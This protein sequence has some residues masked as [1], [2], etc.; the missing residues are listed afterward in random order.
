MSETLTLRQLID[1]T[2]ETLYRTAE[3]PR[4]V[5]LGTAVSSSTIARQIVLTE[6][7]PY[8][9]T[10]DTLEFGS[11]LM[12]VTTKTEQVNPTFTVLRGYAGTTAVDHVFGEIGFINPYW[13]RSV[14]RRHI[15]RF[16]RNIAPVHVPFVEAFLANT[17]FMAAGIGSQSIALD[18]DVID[19][20]DVR[21]QSP[22]TGRIVNVPG[23]HFEDHLPAAISSSGKALKVPSIVSPTDDLLVTVSRRYFFSGSTEDAAIT[24]P[25]GISDIP[26]MWTAAMLASGRE[27]SRLELD[28]LSDETGEA[29]ARAGANVGLLRLLWTNVY[30]RIDEARRIDPKP[31]RLVYNRRGKVYR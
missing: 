9:S 26:S 28:K 11:E 13:P 2:L 16:F 30:R 5:T 7:A 29:A 31:N 19:V 8:V 14:V 3:R 1:E 18:E 10:T 23:W 6:G 4:P 25:D 15:E 20:L 24:M 21:Y 27:V 22:T 12:L 17:T